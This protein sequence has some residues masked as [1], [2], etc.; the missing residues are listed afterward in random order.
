VIEIIVLLAV[1]YVLI[2]LGIVVHET[3]VCDEC[4]DTLQEHGWSLVSFV[5]AMWPVFLWQ[6]LRSKL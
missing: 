4:Y 2:G 3:Y 5:V 6:W 1:A